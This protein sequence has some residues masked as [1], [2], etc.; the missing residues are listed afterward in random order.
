MATSEALKRGFGNF[1]EAIQIIPNKIAQRLEIDAKKKAIADSLKEAYTG[2]T[3]PIGQGWNALFGGDNTGGGSEEAPIITQDPSIK[4]SANPLQETLENMTSNNEANQRREVSTLAKAVNRS[5]VMPTNELAF[6]NNPTGQQFNLE[7][8]IA[9]TQPKPVENLGNNNIPTIQNQVTPIP[10]PTNEIAFGG[11]NP[12]TT[13]TTGTPALKKDQANLSQTS[14]INKIVSPTSLTERNALALALSKVPVVGDMFGGQ[15]ATQTPTTQTTQATQIT[16]PTE[17][18]QNSKVLPQRIYD[19]SKE[20]TAYDNSVSDRAKRLRQMEIDYF[21]S[22]AY[23]NALMWGG[24]PDFDKASKLF[25]SKLSKSEAPEAK[26]HYGADGSIYV[27]TKNG[28]ELAKDG[29]K[30]SKAIKP[31]WKQVPTEI[32]KQGSFGKILQKVFY[33]DE[34]NGADIIDPKTNEPIFSWEATNEPA[35]NVTNVNIDNRE[36]KAFIDPETKGIFNSVVARPRQY[37]Q[38]NTL[39]KQLKKLEEDGKKESADYKLIKKQRETI[40]NTIESTKKAI[41][42][43]VQNDPE[44]KRLSNDAYNAVKNAKVDWN[45]EKAFNIY[46]SHVDAYAEKP[47][48]NADVLRRLYLQSQH[49]WGK[50][51]N[52]AIHNK[53][54][55]NSESMNATDFGT[56]EAKMPTE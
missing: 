54:W 17:Q 48:A 44:T 29:A 12:T 47:D 45:S 42:K 14:S 5:N 46:K 3:S 26:Y 50:V 19:M 21:N 49:T 11:S 8:S 27:E 16:Q 55:L 53:L 31:N 33:K 37:E 52:R 9:E 43:Q 56:E 13:T 23:N 1:N 32:F 7:Q 51:P 15:Q 34:N 36:K 25:D 40:N 38:I 20:R 4:V 18:T 35:R 24:N 39:D 22:D 6:G 28:L 30:N 2:T 10:T 41:D